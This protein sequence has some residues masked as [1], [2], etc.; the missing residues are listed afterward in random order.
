MT[1]ALRP[2]FVGAF[3]LAAVGAFV[4]CDDEDSGATQGPGGPGGDAGASEGG[5]GPSEVPPGPGE[6][7]DRLP[8][9]FETLPQ[10][11]AQLDALAARV[12]PLEP[13]NP[14]FNAMTKALFVDNARPA[15]VGELETALGLAFGD[16][17]ATGENSIGGNP[18]FAL[19]AHS[20][21]LFTR[22]VS[23]INPRAIVLSQM[24]GVPAVI[25]G[26]SVTGYSRGEPFVQVASQNASTK[27][28]TFYLVRFERGCADCTPAQRYGPSADQGWTGFTVYD[29]ED[30]K[31]TI[32]D[33]RQCHQPGGPG[34]PT[35][36]RMQ[37]IDDPWTHWFKIDRPGGKALLDDYSAAHG[38][39][40]S[41]G[42]IPAPLIAK[43]DPR[44][45]EDFVKGQG[46]SDQPNVFPSNTI[47]KEVKASA[48]G[49]PIVNV[50][51]GTS[52]TWDALY[53]GALRGAQIPPPYHDV[54]VTDATK[55]L[56]ATAAYGRLKRGEATELPDLSR[57]FLDDALPDLSF[58]PRPSASAEEILL[59]SCAQCHNGR[60]DPTVSRAKFDATNLAAMSRAEKDLAIERIRLS[61]SNRLAMPPALFRSLPEDAKNK[62]IELLQ[63]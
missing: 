43:S 18:A 53:A 28:I 58:Q 9:P 20:T 30:L 31:N 51:R 44:M 52:A 23:A 26:F 8:D 40:E 33:C 17:D 15:S 24:P 32:V 42:G 25:P 12:G 7:D 38:T 57:V 47:E 10:G 19:T 4:A 27:K 29:E 56:D 49:Q 62:A 61:P 2:L 6:G 50:P 11:Q 39:D 59:H 36:L 54:K 14:S 21:C 22:S 55:L 16:A 48:P 60:L 46:F 35:M 5:P 63:R 37:E 1:P 3:V 34:T 45:L 13:S 41:Y